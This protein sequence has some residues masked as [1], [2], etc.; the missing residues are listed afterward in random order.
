MGRFST[1]AGQV[2]RETRVRLGLSLDDVARISTGRFKPSALGGYERGERSL[3][4]D[5][6]CELASVYSANPDEVLSR[7]LGRLDPAGRD[8]VVIDLRRIGQ[9]ESEERTLVAEFVHRIKVLR[10]DYLTDVLTLRGGDVAALAMA[11][12]RRSDE[13]MIGIRPAL[14]GSEPATDGGGA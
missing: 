1:A 2:L 11:S 9:I 4:I 12:G 7:V 6:F 13:L 14:G 8:E 5:R 3:T 10:G